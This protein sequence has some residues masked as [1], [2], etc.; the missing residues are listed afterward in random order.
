[1]KHDLAA[2]KERIDCADVL[3]MHGHD[4]PGTDIPCPFSA[5]HKNGDR[6]PSFGLFDNGRRYKCQVPTCPA[7]NSGDCI[8][9]QALLDG[10]DKAKAIQA[11]A[12]QAGIKTA[13]VPSKRTRARIVATYDYTDA[14]GNLLFQVCRFDPKAFRQRRPDP[15]KPGAWVWNLNGTERVLYRLPEV[16]D[17]K[18]KGR[19]VLVVE[20]EKDAD[21]LRKLGV[22]ATCNPGGAGKWLDSYTET[23]TGAKI[24][25]FAD[26]DEA[27]RKHAALVLRE[28]TGKAQSAKVVE[29][30]DR[31]GQQVKDPADWIAAGGTVEELREIVRTAPPWQPPME[32][33]PAETKPP[34]KPPSDPLARVRTLIPET[35]FS[36]IGDALRE[37]V[38]ALKGEDKA[39]VALARAECSTKLKELGVAQYTALVNDLFAPACDPDTGT[40]ETG[41]GITLA[42]PEPWPEPVDGNALLQAIKSA[43][44]RYVVLPEQSAIAA[45]LWVLHAHA[46]DAAFIS[47]FLALLSPEKRCGKTTMLQVVGTLSPR[48][49]FASNIT[50]AALFRA[51]EKYRP[52]LLIDEADTFLREREELRGILNSGHTRTT[53]YVVRTVGDNHEAA[54][55][56]T[57]C[58]KVVALIGKLPDTLE[59]RSLVLPL[60]RKGAGENVERLRADK[61][62]C[63][64][65]VCRQAWRWAQDNI[66]ALKTHD[67]DV[68]T[69]LHDR[70]ADNW[71]PLL[72]VAELVGGDWPERARTAATALSCR[73]AGDTESLR[74]MLLSD[75]RNLFDER[76]ADRLFSEDIVEALAEMEDRPWPEM[77]KGK[78]ITKRRLA[79]LLARFKI[80]PKTVR[81]GGETKK[82]YARKDL[83]D[84][85]SRYIPPSI[86]HTVTNPVNTDESALSNRNTEKA[87]YVSESSESPANIELLRCDGSA[88]GDGQEGTLFEEGEI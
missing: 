88:G 53:A 6:N 18:A 78:P 67:P 58:P 20:G 32:D 80:K 36:E 33:T 7:F 63:M 31:N 55:F 69:E 65:P 59:D 34:D 5:G 2:I 40:R 42:D 70:A 22:T 23:L 30:P 15:E 37:V 60:R 71:R 75:I 11:L 9:L 21:A 46:H 87:C 83:E 49:M 14:D 16:L 56:K 44:E 62:E 51:V 54:T 4:W 57:Y 38:A 47:P 39:T 10:G 1:M 64:E 77:S 48:R 45:A 79:S 28:L 27:G 35:P 68:P 8:D 66:D 43:I 24:F 50:P 13:P 26:K 76:N 72:A 85:F 3:R 12:K 41:S 29:L 61:L 19:A 81:I 74:E 82:G 86:R 73:E 52:T 17:A 25:V 84:T